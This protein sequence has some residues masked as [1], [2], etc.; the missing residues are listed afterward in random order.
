MRNKIKIVFIIST[1][2]VGGA[3]I[4][5]LNICRGLLAKDDIFEISILTFFK[6]DALRH[7]FEDFG[8]NVTCLELPK[9]SSVFNILKKIFL[10]YRYIQKIKPQIVHTQLLDT[11]RYGQIAAFFA[12][13]KARICTVHNIEKD[14]ILGFKV[15]RFITGLLATKV[16]F[17]AKCAL[18]HYNSIHS[19]PPK[20]CFVINNAPGFKEKDFLPKKLNLNNRTIKLINIGRL[21][22]QK[23]QINLI[24]AMK[25]LGQSSKNF[26]LHIY[27]GDYLGYQGI[28]EKEIEA[29][30]I[31]NVFFKGVSKDILTILKESDI[32]ISSSLYEAS[33]LVIL[34][35]ITVGIPII[36][37][38]ILPHK[39]ILGEIPEYN[40]F[41]PVNDHEA[42]ANAVEYMTL[43]SDY[44]YKISVGELERSKDYSQER[45]IDNYY[46]LYTRF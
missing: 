6:G 41:V 10:T 1:I 32:F 15:T 38:D 5:L 13:I 18:E 37:T 25:L 17:V 27:G 23:G 8:I 4:L 21:H 11:D 19:Y 36:A 16:I 29:F 12:G 31:R 39:E 42:I 46:N 3:E 24:R 26:E 35:A 7:E 28:L 44:F 30:K 45:L 34:E 33:P 22:T 40:S 2:D 14:E 9:I 43:H 20:K